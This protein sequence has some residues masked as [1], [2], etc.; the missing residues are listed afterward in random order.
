MWNA[1]KASYR[2]RF[3]LT[4]EHDRGELELL[5]SEVQFESEQDCG[6]V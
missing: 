6:G 3:T 4:L 2:R 5:N 1:S